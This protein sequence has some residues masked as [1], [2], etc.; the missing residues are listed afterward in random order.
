MTHSPPGMRHTERLHRVVMSGPLPPAIGGMASV[1]DALGTSRLASQ[2]R[3][4]L[5]DTGKKTAAD[6]TLLQGIQARLRLMRHWT[7]LLAN[8]GGT[9]AHIHTCSGFTF[10]LDGLLA[11]LARRRGCR[12]VLHV[13]GGLFDTFLDGLHPILLRIARRIARTADVV[14]VL[15]EDWRNRLGQRL[16]GTHFAVLQ[17]G[18]HEPNCP[19]QRVANDRPT[20]LFLGNLS[21]L[22]G[23]PVLLEAM[24]LAQADWCVQL[25]GSEAEPGFTEWL[26]QEIERRQL[27]HRVTLLGSVVG[28]AKDRALVRADAFVLP[29]LAEGLPMSLLEAMAA[30]LP[31]VATTVGAI[32][33]VIDEG[34][35]GFLVSPGQA[36][37]LAAAMDQ[38]A[39]SPA[40]REA[41]GHAGHAKYRAHY[42]VDAM[43]Q[44]LLDIYT[45]E[46]G[47]TPAHTTS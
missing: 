29:S 33:E 21:R 15:S 23:V 46:F 9:I 40:Q 38:L 25:A 1:L 17:N 14:I 44:S 8:Q 45:R 11:L 7:A 22:K 30:R 13:H 37:P 6:R 31:V 39:G 28:E 20:F 18:V 36:A 12:V 43:A 19:A 2:T 26:R 34:V 32:P 24:S 35:E 42:S 5:F 3:L 47:A 16:P 27:A 10:F 41:M 4:T